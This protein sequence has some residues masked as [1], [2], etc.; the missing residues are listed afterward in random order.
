MIV[1]IALITITIMILCTVL[2]IFVTLLRDI[3]FANDAPFIPL[4]QSALDCL[5]RHLPDLDHKTFYELGCGDGRILQAVQAHCPTVHCIGVER[6]WRPYVLAKI[7]LHSLVK[8]GAIKLIYN[9]IRRINLA[10]ADIIFTYLMGDFQTELLV[11]FMQ[12]LKNG[13]VVISAQFKI[14]TKKPEQIIKIPNGSS[15]ANKLYFYRF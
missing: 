2:L 1:A 9:D 3:L 15:I 4:D 13:V 12:E 6:G 10:D 11:K 8:S 5:L 14:G 7:R